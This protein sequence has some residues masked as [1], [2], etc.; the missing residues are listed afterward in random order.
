M[1]FFGLSELNNMNLNNVQIKMMQDIESGATELPKTHAE[2][3]GLFTS[4]LLVIDV[5]SIEKPFLDKCRAQIIRTYFAST[6]GKVN[7]D[8]YLSLIK[9][10]LKRR[11]YFRQLEIMCHGR[12]ADAFR[13]SYRKLIEDGYAKSDGMFFKMNE[14]AKELLTN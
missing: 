14:K 8:V 9:N 5:E 12:N 4:I 2:L 1:M 7:E 11:V 6:D 3:Y 10:Q 13:E